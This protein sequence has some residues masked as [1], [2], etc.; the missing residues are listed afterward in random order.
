[1]EL[2][3]WFTACR[4]AVVFSAIETEHKEFI[5]LDGKTCHLVDSGAEIT[6]QTSNVTHWGRGKMADK[7]LTAFSNAFF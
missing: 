7:F 3:R 5:G 4:N 1:M 6:L 2:N